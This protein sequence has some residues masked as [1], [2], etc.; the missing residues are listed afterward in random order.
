MSVRDLYIV[1]LGDDAEDEKLTKQA[2]GRSSSS[3]EV[4]I[5]VY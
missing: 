3:A 4:E 5:I 2:V 1:N